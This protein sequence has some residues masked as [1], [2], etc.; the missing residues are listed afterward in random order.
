VAE[1]SVDFT[2][3]LSGNV[4]G[5]QG[6]TVVNSVG[7]QS[8]ANVANAA[9]AIGSA[10]QNNVPGTLVMRDG[11]G[12]F[13]GQTIN[14]VTQYNI[15]GNRLISVLGTNNLFVGLNSGTAITTGTDNTFFG[16]DAG[17]SDTSSR[18]NSFFGSGAGIS[19]MPGGNFNSF[20]GQSAGSANTTGHDNAF[21]GQAAGI[22]NKSGSA[23][24]AFGLGAGLRN[25]TGNGNTFVGF[26]AGD[27][28]T[29]GGDNTVIGK[30]ANVGSPDLS[31]ATALGSGAIVNASNTVVLGRAA[32]KV[33]A[34]GLLQVNTLGA[35]GST[36]LCRNSVNQISTCTAGNL[37]E[38]TAE[39]TVAINELRERNT[40]LSEKV[41]RQERKISALT[42]LVCATNPEEGF[43]KG[44]LK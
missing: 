12:G 2:G 15:G 34:P 26:L 22:G 39:Q 9:T 8:A 27:R 29:T 28:N 21:F 36:S 4:T 38:V 41:E 33:L 32:D 5:T 6:S 37:T 18:S 17:R 16:S 3:E 11:S 30:S 40:L 1:S 25:T 7:G 42:K 19:I 35:A 10:T 44:D 23:N 14:A 43:C 31:F 20:F 24:V 13:S